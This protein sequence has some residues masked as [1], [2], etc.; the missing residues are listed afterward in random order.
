MDEELIVFF[1][2]NCLLCQ[3]AVKW[4]NR[5]DGN[6]R[7]KFAPLQGETAG[8]YEIDLSDDSMAFAERG[9]IYRA[10]EAARR[11][12]W[13]AGGGGIFLAFLITAL[14]IALRDWGYQWIA[15]NRKRLVKNTRCDLPEEG[16]NRKTLN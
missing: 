1:D 2:G 15:K 5:I 7:L 4:L 11:A 16:M 6:D 13:N 14:P 12:F 3:G 9:N 10:S 8:R